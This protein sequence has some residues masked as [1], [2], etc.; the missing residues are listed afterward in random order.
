MDLGE[1]KTRYRTEV[2]YT[3]I[4]WVM[5]RLIA[6]LFPGIYKKQAHKWIENF[7]RLLD[8][9]NSSVN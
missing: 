2:V 8:K 3:R 9:E 4:N 1:N 7:K 5:P 6:L